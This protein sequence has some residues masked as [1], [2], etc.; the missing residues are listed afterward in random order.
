MKQNET[1]STM[2]LMTPQE[3]IDSITSFSAA[4]AYTYT[5]IA[6]ATVALKKQIPMKPLQI[7]G[8]PVWGYCPECGQV[9][10]RSKDHIGCSNCLQRLTWD[11]SGVA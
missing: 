5:A 2:L 3:A 10:S 11:E 7:Q 9:V 4:H 6:T 8:Y 1:N